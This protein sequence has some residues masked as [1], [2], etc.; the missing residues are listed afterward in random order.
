MDYD[1][2]NIDELR[3]QIVF[4]KQEKL[5]QE[6]YFEQKYI[7]VKKVFTSPISFIKDS[8]N[9]SGLRPNQTSFSADYIT[10]IARAFLPIILNKTLLKGRGI[11]VK[12]LI[13][14]LSQRA[15]NAK[16]INKDIL[17]HWVD[18]ITEFIGSKSKVS[19][20]KDYGIPE[21]SETY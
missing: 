17:S 5:E 11:F 15:I 8:F 7:S 1:F 18:N 4:L 9:F 19:K 13:T 21:D 10:N 20:S 14:F 2:K 3:N 6:L 16:I 12:T